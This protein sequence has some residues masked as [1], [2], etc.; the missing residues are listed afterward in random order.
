MARLRFVQN[1]NNIIDNEIKRQS[2]PLFNYVEKMRKFN[3]AP[4]RKWRVRFCVTRL[5]LSQCKCI[6]NVFESYPK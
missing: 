2:N 3:M 1:E 5:K 6:E 4:N